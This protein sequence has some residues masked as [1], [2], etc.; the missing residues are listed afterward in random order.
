M[1]FKEN[2]SPGFF[3][4]LVSTS[5]SDAKDQAAKAK[6]REEKITIQNRKGVVVFDQFYHER[7]KAMPDSAAALRASLDQ[8]EVLGINYVIAS[9]DPINEEFAYNVTL[10]TMNTEEI[11]K[12]LDNAELSLDQGS[13]F[14]K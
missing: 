4:K 2:P 12:V 8:L 5:E 3:K 13:L 9:K 14:T 6:N 7:L 10:P 11:S 1:D